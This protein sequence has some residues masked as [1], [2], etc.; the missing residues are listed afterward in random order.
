MIKPLVI[1][2]CLVM[3]GCSLPPVKLQSFQAV[4]VHNVRLRGT[5]LEAGE[6]MLFLPVTK[7]TLTEERKLAIILTVKNL[8][9]Q[10]PQ[11]ETKTIMILFQEPIRP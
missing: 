8:L 1:S 6:R 7:E 4:P 10:L 3:M 5:S 9:D 2:L 11:I